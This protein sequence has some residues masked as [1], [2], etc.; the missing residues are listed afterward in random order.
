MGDGPGQAL[1]GNVPG[2]LVPAQNQDQR[3]AGEGEGIGVIYLKR[4]F[5]G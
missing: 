4:G 3:V 5:H 1:V 2:P